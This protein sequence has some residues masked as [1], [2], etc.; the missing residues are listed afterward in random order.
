M[1]IILT[2]NVPSLGDKGDVVNVSDGYARNYLVPKKFAV[3]ASDGA[4]KQADAMRQSRIDFERKSLEEAQQLADSLAGTRVVVAARAGDAGNLFGSIG[5]ND[6]AEAIVKF[7][8]IDIDRKII[9]IDEPIKEIG[10]HEIM[11]EPH[12]DVTVTVTLDVIPA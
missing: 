6:V 11:L 1:K 10:L 4:L 9:A 3:K 5:V 2:K 7:T 12:T 8:G